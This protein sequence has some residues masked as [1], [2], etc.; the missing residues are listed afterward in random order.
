M[1]RE[2]LTRRALLGQAAKAAIALP[3]L[4]AMMP[5]TRLY[6][7]DAPAPAAVMPK[8]LCVIYVP[9]GMLM[10]S[11]TPAKTGRDFPLSPTLEPLAPLNGR[12]S[13]VGNTMMDVGAGIMH[14]AGE[15]FLTNERIPENTGKYLPNR[16]S[17]DRLV[18]RR[19]AG[20]TL[21]DSLQLSLSGAGGSGLRNTVAYDEKGMPL[22]GRNDPQAV[23]ELLFGSATD[24]EAQRAAVSDQRSVLDAVAPQVQALSGRLGR[25]DRRVLEEYLDS[26]RETERYIQRLEQRIDRP[27]TPADQGLVLD[28]SK[29]STRMRNMLDLI[30]LAFRGD[31]TRVAT[32]VV[33]KERAD[34]EQQYPELGLV[35]EHHGWTHDSAENPDPA[36]RESVRKILATVDRFHT[37]QVAYF[38][39]RL[40]DTPEG[41]G[42]MLDH[43]LVL[44]GSGLC[45]I[46]NAIH[47]PRDLPLVL[48][49]GE[50]MGL[51]QGQHVR[52][53]QPENLANLHL[54]LLQRLGVDCP[55]WKDSTRVLSELVA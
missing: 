53:E 23:F 49:G 27:T 42:T 55:Q 39:Q 24:P 8:R 18:A 29:V 44:Y 15:M 31:L 54:T 3:F 30:Y 50:A 10:S 1:T 38:L 19:N 47:D 28:G 6:G 9:H 45:V 4:R 37:E 51:R 20:Q 36:K 35:G 26:I 12:F 33:F 11:F 22:M 46:D 25:G 40:R 7:G 34:G 2:P 17:M 13:V 32:F 52:Y 43:T 16:L 14:R 41:D 21:L 48:A 5:L